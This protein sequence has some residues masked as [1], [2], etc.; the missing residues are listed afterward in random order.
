MSAYYLYSSELTHYGVKGM[1]W[2]VRHER[3][4]MGGR[5]HR[6]LAGVYGIN[7]RFYNRT[8]NRTLAS[9]NAAARTQQLRKAEQADLKKRNMT[10]EQ[11]KAIRNKR[12][13]RAAIIGGTAAAAA[14]A[15]YGHHKYTGLKKEMTSMNRSI[16][17]GQSMVRD[18][19][20][21]DNEFKNNKNQL[22]KSSVKYIGNDF[23][24][25][26]AVRDASGFINP[27][28]D[29]QRTFKNVRDYAKAKKRYMGHY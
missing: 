12:V 21:S 11:R 15:I 7:Q 17:F 24:Y 18:L 5:M 23:K 16:R 28:V 27:T 4:S 13:K 14:L 2:G 20:N 22:L 19:Y 25:H 8:G 1:K 26:T 10:P 3:P 6:A 9:M 29:K